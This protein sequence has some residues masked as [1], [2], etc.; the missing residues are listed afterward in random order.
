MNTVLTGAALPPPAA[1]LTATTLGTTGIV[2]SPLALGCARLG[3][4][5]S[6]LSRKQS[7][8]LLEEAVALGLRHFDTASIYGQGDSER[9]LGAALKAHRPEL[10]LATKA[11]QRL[12]ALQAL[13]ARF[14]GPIRLLSR[15]RAGVRQAVAE[16]RAAGVNRCF[17]PGFLLR[18]LEG[19]LRRLGT[20]HVDIFY[21]HSPPAA[22]L[23][24]DEVLLLGER[25]K[26]AGKIRCFG[27]S[28]DDLDTALLA[29][30]LP[31]VE[32]VQ[33]EPDGSATSDAIF[34]SLHRHG[35]LALV[36]GIVRRSGGTEEALGRAFHQVLA[37][38]AVGGVI[39]GTT[40]LDHLRHNVDAFLH[41]A[42]RLKP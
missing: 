14:K 11:G 2:T 40:R 13:A 21:L 34:A 6:P 41:H 32:I 9:Y 33:F 20:D 39:V 27:V 28:C 10:C 12:S 8:R 16:R 29:A 17:A 18:S 15:Y 42:P 3:S 31:A 36:R 24:A 37:Q 35:K 1:S 5:L 22:A 19:S 30:R 38:P 7:Y 4:T 25:L 26:Q 23:Q